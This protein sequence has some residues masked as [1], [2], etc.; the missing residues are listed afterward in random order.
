MAKRIV[1]FPVNGWRWAF[2]TSPLSISEGT[3]STQA[4]FVQMW[5]GA[6]K[7]VSSGKGLVENLRP[8]THFVSDKMEQQWIALGA[9]KERSVKNRLHRMGE[10]LLAKI[11]PSETFLKSMS[12]DANELEIVFPP[13]L[14]SRLVRRRVRHMAKSGA[15]IHSRYMYGSFACLPFSIL[16]GIV[17]VPNV[18]LFWNLFRAYANWQALEGS[19][20]LLEFVSDG[21][22]PM[23]SNQECMIKENSQQQSTKQRVIFSPSKTLDGML[24]HQKGEA[25]KVTDTSIV[26]ICEHYHLDYLQILKWRDF[27][28]KKGKMAS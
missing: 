10:K 18:P 28:Y 9:A 21:S 2:S 27:E 5:L 26:R 3:S 14:N 19:R 15:Q 7:D 13:S 12:K 11:T 23:E 25:E 20:R 8:L 6:C 1:V 4:T 22:D 24:Q 17:P 16:F